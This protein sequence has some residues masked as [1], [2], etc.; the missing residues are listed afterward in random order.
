[1]LVDLTVK[2]S[3]EIN[4]NAADNEKKVSYGHLGTHFDVMNQEFPLEFVKR[5]AIVF[6]VRN[7]LNRDISIQ[8][9]NI[10]LVQKNMFVAFYTE[11]IEQEP[12]GSKAYFTKHPQLSDE[13]INILLEKEISIIGIDCAGVRRGKEHTPKDQYCAD[14]GV[15]IVENLCNLSEILEERKSNTFVANTYPL[16]FSGMT[17]LPCRV[18]AEFRKESC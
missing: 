14:R 15:F 9:I 17:G 16:N 3:P 12:Y 11:F 7:I 1:M 18:V 10:E 13:L 2:I 4:K 6:D 8:D 5:K